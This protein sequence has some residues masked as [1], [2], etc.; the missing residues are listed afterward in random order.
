MSTMKF[1]KKILPH[2]IA[3]HI[4]LNVY[5]FASMLEAPKASVVIAHIV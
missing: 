2:M 5:S 1:M 4:K 3:F